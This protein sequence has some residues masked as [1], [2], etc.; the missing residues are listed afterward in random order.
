M[1]S[2]AARDVLC[3]LRQRLAA[4]DIASTG[5]N[6]SFPLRAE[7]A[8][9]PLGLPAIDSVLA[10]GFAVGALHELAPVAPHHLGAAMGFALAVATLN[11][12]GNASGRKALWIQTDFAG[13]EGGAP[14]GP[15]LDLFGLA[16]ERILVLSVARPI[17][18]LWAAEEALKS[19]AL[20]AV[21][22]ELP[23]QGAAADLTATR[24]LSLAA[25]AGGGLGLLIRHQRTPL[26]SPAMTRWEVAGAPTTPDRFGGMGRTAF[27]LSLQ[28]NRR[29]PCGRFIV[30]WDHVARVFIPQALPLGL[31]AAAH[32]RSHDALFARLG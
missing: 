31:A 23:Q 3:H 19:R 9:R 10:G 15:G 12:A 20:L 2:A 5:E 14:Y 32:D 4:Q 1:P 22:A 11:A 25:R 18:A 24:R 26:P 30:S 28:R 21:V 7:E 29:G 17:D 13:L 6:F 8:L 27:D 16:M